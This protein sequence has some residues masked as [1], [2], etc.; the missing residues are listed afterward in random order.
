MNQRSNSSE[1]LNPITSL[2]YRAVVLILGIPFLS[3]KKSTVPYMDWCFLGKP[4]DAK[5][6][7]KILSSVGVD[8]DSDKVGFDF[9]SFLIFFCLLSSVRYRQWQV[10][11]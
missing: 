6:I 2:K 8:A 4:V 1:T 5:S 3:V 7:E 11:R 9:F 10:K